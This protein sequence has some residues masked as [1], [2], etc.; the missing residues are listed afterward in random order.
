[1]LLLPRLPCLLLGRVG[2]LS[3]CVHLGLRRRD[4][5]LGGGLR[6]SNAR[7]CLQPGCIYRI[8][9]SLRDVCSLSHSVC[10]L[11]RRG[12]CLA[13]GALGFKGRPMS[14][15]HRLCGCLNQTRV[16]RLQIYGGPCDLD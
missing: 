15:V 13:A 9:R 14:V 4:N 2:P 12:L 5:L 8:R 6:L 10:G 11:S 3:I 1:M 7:V 16:R